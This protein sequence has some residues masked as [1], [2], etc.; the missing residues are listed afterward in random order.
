[1]TPPKTLTNEEAEKLLLTLLGTPHTR[2]AGIQSLRNYAIALLMLDAGLRVGEVCRLVTTDLIV[3]DEPVHTLRLSA[4]ITKSHVER[5]VPLSQR[6]QNVISILHKR[7]WS[8]PLIHDSAFAFPSADP[9]YHITPRQVQRII[10]RAA[11]LA[12]GRSIHPHV[13]RHTFASRLMRQTNARVVQQLLGHKNIQTTQIYT[14]PNSQDCR[15]AI[16]G[17]SNNLTNGNSQET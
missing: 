7:R 3:M 9:A 15:K 5:E 11:V 14:H 17:L 10:K 16:D 6:L 4:K 2:L 13:L 1:M 12:L 8:A